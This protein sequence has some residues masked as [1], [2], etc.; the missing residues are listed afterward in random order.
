MVKSYLQ[1]GSFM[2]LTFLKQ[3]FVVFSMAVLTACS[4]SIHPET[5]V[6][7]DPLEGVNRAMWKVNYEYLDPYILKPVAKGWR[8]YVPS[9]VKTGLINVTN[10][11]DEP[12]SFINRLIEGEGKKAM[13]HFNRFWI[14]TI[15]GLGGLIDW[16]SQDEG[17]RLSNGQRGL[18]ESLGTYG[19]SSGSY[20]MVP[21]YGATTPRQAIGGALETGYSI[22][23]YV[24]IP[25][26]LSKFV[27][28][29]VDSRAKLL[30]KDALL[31]QSQDPYV[32]FREAYFQNLEFKVKDG[33]V[34][35]NQQEQ[36]SEEELKNI[37]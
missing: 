36:L 29:G 24:G 15:F 30:D 13:V 10:N 26:S 11:L 18:G 12:V 1:K 28:Q 5:G 32:T 33:N 8:D 9:P 19:V 35:S 20:I 21:A 27:V 16:A 25:W 7:D 4:S 6:R 14:N 2:K 37:D 22:L 31:Q 34:E 17:L 23:T 3:I